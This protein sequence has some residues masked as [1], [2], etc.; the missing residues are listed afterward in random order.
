MT[1]AS[2][3]DTATM[4]AARDGVVITRPAVTVMKPMAT[5][6]PS[7][8]PPRSSRPVGRGSN[9]VPGV[10]SS[11]AIP[12]RTVRNANGVANA[13]ALFTA[14][15]VVPHRNVA[16]SSVR[17]ACRRVTRSA[18]RVQHAAHLIRQPPRR[19]RLLQEGGP[20][21]RA[22]GGGARR[23][24][25]RQVD[26]DRGATARRPVHG[27][28]PAALTHD[29]VHGGESQPGALAAWLGGEERLEQVCLDLVVHADPAVRHLE[30]HMTS[31]Q[32]SWGEPPSRAGRV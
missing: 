3:E 27:D 28:V 30:Q 11:V 1:G 13:S 8:N 22:S 23:R 2:T 16:S 18:G 31:V 21:V 5:R 24:D 29:A 17:S 20:G 7:S 15:K 6:A 32:E 25:A 14:T 19:E 26:A 12:N 9:Q 10:S 4:N